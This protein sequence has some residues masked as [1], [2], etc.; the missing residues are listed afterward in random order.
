MPCRFAAALK[1][2][3]HGWHASG[4]GGDGRAGGR[5][6]AGGGGGGGP[7]LGIWVDG[8]SPTLGQVAFT[9]GPAGLGGFSSGA[10]GAGQAGASK[11][12]GP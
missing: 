10:Q 4:K 8:A 6:G 12:V 5:G 2:F 11:N 3:H 1:S 9:L 7:S